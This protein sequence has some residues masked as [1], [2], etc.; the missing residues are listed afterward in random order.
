MQGT[1]K[2][3][4]EELKEDKNNNDLIIISSDEERGNADTHVKRS[5]CK[6]QKKVAKGKKFKNEVL[7]LLIQSKELKIY[8]VTFL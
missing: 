5:S 7:H 8:H 2:S 3:D 6:R 4:L 1:S